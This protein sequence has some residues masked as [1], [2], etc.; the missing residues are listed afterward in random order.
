MSPIL[1]TIHTISIGTM[2]NFNGGKNG[3]GLKNVT[4]RVVNVIM[5]YTVSFGWISTKPRISGTE[6]DFGELEWEDKRRRKKDD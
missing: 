1:S 4:F 2:L 3:Q 5:A 6:R